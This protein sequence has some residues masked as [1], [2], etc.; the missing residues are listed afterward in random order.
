MS[1]QV[2]FQYVKANF[3]TSITMVVYQKM[4][5]PYIMAHQIS[6]EA[7]VW[8]PALNQGWNVLIMLNQLQSQLLLFRHSIRQIL[9]QIIPTTTF[10]FFKVKKLSP[11]SMIFNERIGYLESTTDRIVAN[12]DH[13]LDILSNKTFPTNHLDMMI[14]CYVTL[15]IIPPLTVK[16]Q[17]QGSVN[18]VIHAHHFPISLW[19]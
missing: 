13:V 5:H 8:T 3:T 6:L 7:E 10:I 19:Q 2:L 1:S 17:F 4:D 11:S 15:R 14:P 18:N 9:L 12:V 16:H